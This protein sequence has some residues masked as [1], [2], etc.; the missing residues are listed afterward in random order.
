MLIFNRYNVYHICHFS[1]VGYF[2]IIYLVCKNLYLQSTVTC[3]KLSDKCRKK[4]TMFSSEI[5]G[6]E[7]LLV[8]E[9]K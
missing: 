8:D 5:E 2:F 9:V 1:L 3:Y 4:S 6:P 7:S